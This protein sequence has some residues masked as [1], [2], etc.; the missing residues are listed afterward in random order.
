MERPRSYQPYDPLAQATNAQNYTGDFV[1]AWNIATYNNSVPLS[2][3]PTTGLLDA[4]VRWLPPP[5]DMS[6]DYVQGKIGIICDPT[7]PWGKNRRAPMRLSDR[8]SEAQNIRAMNIFLHLPA[9]FEWSNIPQEV[10][11][12]KISF[13]AATLIA[14]AR[15]L[16]KDSKRPY[17]TN[18]PYPPAFHERTH[19]ID[20]S[21]SV[22]VNRKL[23]AAKHNLPVGFWQKT[24]PRSCNQATN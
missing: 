15:P 5:S 13:Y 24:H 12:R 2:E 11:G 10:G 18:Y 7:Q 17:T 23:W 16:A 9:D 6:K 19:L 21:R 1:D 22:H 14:K 8:L 3:K 4:D 20:C